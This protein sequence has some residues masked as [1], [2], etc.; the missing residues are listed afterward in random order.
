MEEKCPYKTLAAGSS[1]VPTTISSRHRTQ[2]D[3]GQTDVHSRGF[4]VHA[5][6]GTLGPDSDRRDDDWNT[7]ITLSLWWRSPSGPRPLAVN[8]GS[9][10]QIWYVTPFY[11]NSS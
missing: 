4:H 3:I 2:V 11:I 5:I 9:P 6:S 7:V 1:P 10:V 8:R